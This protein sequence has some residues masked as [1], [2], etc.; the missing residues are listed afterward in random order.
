MYEI[1]NLI[2]KEKKEIEVEI[3]DQRINKVKIENEVKEKK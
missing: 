2:K 1:E 3:K